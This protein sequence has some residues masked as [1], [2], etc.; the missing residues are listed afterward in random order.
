MNIYG[1]AS[2]SSSSSSSTAPATTAAPTITGGDQIVYRTVTV[3]STV[4]VN[5]C[6]SPAAT[7][8]KRMFEGRRYP[9]PRNIRD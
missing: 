8:T 4:T 7:L 9:V 5:T 1:P 2:S 3:T 6:Q